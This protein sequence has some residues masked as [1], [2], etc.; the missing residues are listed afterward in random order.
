[1]TLVTAVIYRNKFLK[2]KRYTIHQ[3]ERLFLLSSNVQTKVTSLLQY[4]LPM[5]AQDWAE[6]TWEIINYRRF[7]N[8]LL[9]DITSIRQLKK[10]NKNIDRQ[11]NAYHGQSNMY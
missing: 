6:S 1:M 9:P 11:K 4:N 2:N 8:Q 7:I 5:M 10:V 3:Y